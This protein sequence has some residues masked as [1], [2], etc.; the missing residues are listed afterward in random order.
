MMLRIARAAALLLV[1]APALLTPVVCVGQTPAP[2]AA[3]PSGGPAGGAAPA[4]VLLCPKCHH[5]NP[6][7][8]RFCAECGAVLR[9][10]GCPRC[11]AEI[12][13]G[14]KF[15]TQC[16]LD[17]RVVM[18]KPQTPPAPPTPQQPAAAPPPPDTQAMAAEEVTYPTLKIGGFGNIDYTGNSH[19]SPHGFNLGQ[20]VLHTNSL[21]SRNM[22]FFS[23]LSL[24]P[25]ADVGQGNPP[26][27]GYAADVERA[28]LRYDQS[29]LLRVSVGRYHT[30]INWWNT[31]YHHGL[32]LQT[33]I[34]RPEM[35]KFGGQFIPVH[36]VGGLLEGSV[37]SG[38]LGLNYKV[39]LGNG[40]SSV[41][42]RAGD[43]GDS[44][45]ALAW[46]LNLYVRPER[47]Y[48][49]QVGGAVYRDNINL[50]SGRRFNEWITSAHVV[51]ETETPEI[52][53]E[54]AHVNHKELG[55][56]SANS[57]AWYIQG[58]YRLPWANK[59]FKPYFRYE[60]IW[61]PRGEPVFTAVPSLVGSLGGVRWDFA[62]FAAL[63]V[64]YRDFRHSVPPNST[65]F[66]AQVSYVF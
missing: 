27:A 2:P 26:A 65:G 8:A 31:A 41:V 15:C 42:S 24:T 54:Y 18:T 43:F 7:T 3:G 5:E 48:G 23:E 9:Q 56:A 19:N 14:Q 29:D 6:P 59:K 37:P 11:G 58:A 63:K 20:Y 50:L 60:R 52:I 13:P 22:Q 36:F 45:N 66:F 10:G 28:I 49:L 1:V 21:L 47:L 51:L 17:L 44:N 39:G 33:T 62:D 32:W 57:D 38:G 46:L 34:F 53:A 25:R 30:P 61:V 64:E 40:R 16:G 4:Q 12:A 55:G 35:A